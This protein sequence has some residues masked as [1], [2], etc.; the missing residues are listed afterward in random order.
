[1]YNLLLKAFTLRV[2]W[3]LAL[4]AL[5]RAVIPSLALKSKWAPPFFRAF[6]TST[7]LSSWTAKVRGVSKEENSMFLKKD[8]Q[9]CKIKNTCFK[10]F[11]LKMLL[12]ENHKLSIFSFGQQNHIDSIS[13]KLWRQQKECVRLSL[14]INLGWTNPR[15][16]FMQLVLLFWPPLSR[17]W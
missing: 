3:F 9:I 6:I 10:N 5:C 15:Y 11:K 17:S 14:L 4:A 12:K 1:M 2:T 16:Y 13:L 8:E 7:V